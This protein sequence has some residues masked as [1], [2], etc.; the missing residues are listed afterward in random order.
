MEGGTNENAARIHR[1]A[2][3]R[4]DIPTRLHTHTAYLMRD[5]P[6]LQHSMNTAPGI[7]RL[8]QNMQSVL[9]ATPTGKESTIHKMAAISFSQ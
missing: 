5:G 8:S 6:Q 2:H 4:T 1:H 7:D 9:H 3:A